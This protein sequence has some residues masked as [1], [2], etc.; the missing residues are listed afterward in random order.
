MEETAEVQT[1]AKPEPKKKKIRNYTEGPMFWNMVKFIIPNFLTY[2][3]LFSFNAA[4]SIV[5]GNFGGD[6]AEARA[7]ALAAVG[8]CGNIVGMFTIAFTEFSAGVSISAAYAIGKKDNERLEKV[9][10]TS[11]TFGAIVSLIVTA[12]GLLF[13]P[14]LLRLTNMSDEMIPDALRYLRAYLF[15]VPALI[16]NTYGIATLRASGDATRP[17]IFQ[18]ISGL[19]NIGLNLLTVIVFDWGAMGVGIA[20][21]V[22]TWATTL[23]LFIYI[24]RKTSPIRFHFRKIGI[25]FSVLKTTL[26]LGVPAA[27]LGLCN[28]LSS[29]IQ[30]SAF[31]SLGAEIV[32]GNTAGNQI[33]RFIYAL[34]ASCV[35]AANVVV[36]QN[37]A[38]RKFDRI[39][40]AM[41]Y[42]VIMITAVGVL[43]PILILGFGTKLIELFAPGNQA[44]ID[45]GMVRLTHLSIIYFIFGYTNLILGALNAIK[46]PMYTMIISLICFAGIRILWVYTFFRWYPSQETLYYSYPV[47][48]ISNA[49]A[50]LIFFLYFYKQEKKKELLGLR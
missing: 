49:L 50:G 27:I 40:R 42:A 17:L 21:T 16:L 14:S 32:A 24:T 9:L 41:F 31:N 5:V 11:L 7:I 35:V 30:Q 6:S 26:L 2:V 38:A 18:I 48:W 36:G 34:V 19:V 47:I 29:L 25:D 44:A 23:V 1:E 37:F 45:A 20:T 13:A 22:S 39:K 43:D 46:K 3:V 12:A 4:D 8:A 10:H 15:C 28:E 33:D